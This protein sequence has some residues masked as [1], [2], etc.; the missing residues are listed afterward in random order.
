MQPMFNDG[1]KVW[2]YSWAFLFNSPKKNDVVVFTHNNIFLMKRVNNISKDK[3]FL[4]GDNKTD[5]M[6]SSS[7][8]P[9]DKN[10]ILGKVIK[11][12]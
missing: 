9:I 4:S 6:D 1:E 2:S 12:Y 10:K 3:Y 8:G 7:F 5:S 11:K